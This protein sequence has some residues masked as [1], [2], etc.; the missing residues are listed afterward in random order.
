MVLEYGPLLCRQCLIY[1]IFMGEGAC[2]RAG[3]SEA[4]EEEEEEEFI[5]NRPLVRRDS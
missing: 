4:G 5:Q 1:C 2:C 3:L